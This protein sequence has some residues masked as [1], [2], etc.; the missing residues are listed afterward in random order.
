MDY[1]NS[2]LWVSQ[3]KIEGFVNMDLIDK[4]VKIMKINNDK[5]VAALGKYV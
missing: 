5:A 3:M 1:R 4:F 2:L